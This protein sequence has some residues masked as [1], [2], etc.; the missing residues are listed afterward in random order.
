MI[1]KEGATAICGILAASSAAGLPAARAAGFAASQAAP[2]VDVVNFASYWRDSLMRAAQNWS[3]AG[4]NPSSRLRANL[5][6][7]AIAPS[8]LLRLAVRSLR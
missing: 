8:L 2:L 4:S 5:R 7:S 1:A 3:M 6:C